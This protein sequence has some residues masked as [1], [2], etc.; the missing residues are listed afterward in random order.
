MFKG[1]RLIVALQSSPVSKRGSNPIGKVVNPVGTVITVS[2]PSDEEANS[3]DYSAVEEGSN[4]GSE[5]IVKWPTIIKGKNENISESCIELSEHGREINTKL[6]KGNNCSLEQ[7]ES[8]NIALNKTQSSAKTVTRVNNLTSGSYSCFQEKRNSRTQE[9]AQILK[10]KDK[11]QKKKKQKGE[12]EIEDFS[13]KIRLP[14]ENLNL[15]AKQTEKINTEKNISG[16]ITS[17]SELEEKL[18]MG[19]KNNDKLV[20]ICISSTDTV[21]VTTNDSLKYSFKDI[22]AKE[23]SMEVFN[24]SITTCTKTEQDLPQTIDE[25]IPKNSWGQNNTL[26]EERSNQINEMNDNCTDTDVSRNRLCKNSKV[27]K[28]QSAVVEG[29]DIYP[30]SIQTS[31]HS[32]NK[33][34]KTEVR[35]KKERKRDLYDTQNHIRLP[36]SWS[37]V[38]SSVSK[39]DSCKSEQG[40]SEYLDCIPNELIKVCPSN[41]SAL[42]KDCFETDEL[43]VATSDRNFEC[44]KCYMKDFKSDEKN[45][46]CVEKNV[47]K[48]STPVES[49]IKENGKNKKI[50]SNRSI[51]DE[52]ESENAYKPTYCSTSLIQVGSSSTDDCSDDS[53]DLC[54]L[55]LKED[56]KAQQLPENLFDS[57]ATTVD[58]NLGNTATNGEL[59][60]T[61]YI[62]SK[63]NR[64]TKKKRR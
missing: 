47:E 20:K 14:K 17:Q 64:R 56:E 58:E 9:N 46:S 32:E 31:R 49:I 29:S 62:G 53:K 13:I 27:Q 21:N 59:V 61:S 51:G 55:N 37:S 34:L 36:R 41:E 16:T 26:I 40:M 19:N 54:D 30:D 5:I 11:S 24:N 1:R 4:H 10:D 52:L 18:I 3:M 15:I 50:D 45:C 7:T 42:R 38:V 63:K 57:P 43:S 23:Q 25:D 28:L 44:Q 33:I 22:N 8:F 2:V 60:N 39:S 12:D 35:N 48:F 6:F